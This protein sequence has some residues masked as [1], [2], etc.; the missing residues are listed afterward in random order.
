MEEVTESYIKNL[1]DRNLLLCSDFLSIDM[2]YFYYF[3][4][5]V[6]ELCLRVATKEIFY[7]AQRLI[8]G[9]HHLI[10]DERNARWCFSPKSLATFERPSLLRP[11]PFS[12]H[13]PREAPIKFRLLRVCFEDIHFLNLFPLVNMRFFMNCDGIMPIRYLLPS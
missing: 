1:V 5:V 9:E 3:H 8:G 11:L 2:L 4:D 6:R 13:L 7:C 10:A 12:G